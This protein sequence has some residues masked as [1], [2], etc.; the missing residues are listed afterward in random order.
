MKD[1]NYYIREINYLETKLCTL[2]EANEEKSKFIRKM[3]VMKKIL[4]VLVVALI[5]YLAYFIKVTN[6]AIFS[7]V[8]LL[9]AITATLGSLSCVFVLSGKVI[10]E[11]KE[12]KSIYD[13]KIAET[14][15]QLKSVTIKR[16]NC[17]ANN[18][19]KNNIILYENIVKNKV[20]NTNQKAKAY[21][22]L[23][24]KDNK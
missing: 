19:E 12:E 17:L 3:S 24:R 9:G 22:R 4:A 23:L 21:I 2:N 20:E 18:L 16:D 7:N 11:T 15:K 5:P 10:K 14:K 6:L 8:Y 13:E 1:I